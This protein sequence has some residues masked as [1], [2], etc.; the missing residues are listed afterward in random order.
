MTEIRNI[1]D[2]IRLEPGGKFSQFYCVKI[3]ISTLRIRWYEGRELRCQWIDLEE[4]L[5][6]LLRLRI[7]SVSTQIL[8]PCSSKFPGLS[9][10]FQN[11]LAR[12]TERSTRQTISK[13]ALDWPTQ[14]SGWVCRSI[15]HTA[16]IHQPYASSSIGYD[17][18]PKYITLTNILSSKLLTM[19]GIKVDARDG[20]R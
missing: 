5:L 20:T 10:A 16:E 13:F 6:L 19:L 9:G 2:N 17:V 4:R 18:I 7:D 3:K 14:C 12:L 15:D 11:V 8:Y 1:L